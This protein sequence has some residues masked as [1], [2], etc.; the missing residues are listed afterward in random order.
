MG[1]PGT[2]ACLRCH[3][4][5]FGGDIYVDEADPS[6]MP[7]I[8]APGAG[9]PAWVHLGTFFL[10]AGTENAVTLTNYSRSPWVVADAMEDLTSLFEEEGWM[11]KFPP[12]LID[13]LSTDDGIWSVPVNIHRANVL[14]YNPAILEA[15][16]VAVPTGQTK[17]GP[18]RAPQ[19]P[20][21]IKAG[22]AQCWSTSQPGPIQVRPNQCPTCR[23]PAILTTWST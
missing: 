11:D 14:W 8:A 17:Y 22:L 15:N 23:M 2:A 5:N 10:T 9:L 18:P 6:F 21:S 4:H 16:G 19:N 3:Q 7:S 12:G 13:L 20:I 1:R